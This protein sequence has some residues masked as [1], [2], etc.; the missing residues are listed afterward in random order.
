MSVETI[1]CMLK[2]SKPFHTHIVAIVYTH[3]D[4]PINHE[5][6]AE[7]EAEYKD[8][9]LEGMED[10]KSIILHLLS[11]LKLG[12]DLTKVTIRHTSCLM[13]VAQMISGAPN[14]SLG[15]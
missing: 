15:Q 2:L 10:H 12:M 5:E 6:E 3:T 1:V 14:C 7:D 9:D 13:A 4:G 8:K 11:Q